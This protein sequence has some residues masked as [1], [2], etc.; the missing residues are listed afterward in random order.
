MHAS[1]ASQHGHQNI[2]IHT[3]D[4]DVVVLAIAMAENMQPECKLWV[5]IG[6]GNNLR[7]ITAQ[8]LAASLGPDRAKSLPVFHAQSGCDTVSSFAGHG[9]KTAW[10]TWNM[11]P[12]LTGALL[13]LSSASR[14]IPEDVMLTIKRFVILMYD[15]TSTCTNI[16]K[17]RKNIFEKKNNV[18]LIQVTKA[19]FDDHVK[20]AAYQGGHI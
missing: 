18:Q 1:H 2:L 17:A 11:L 6:T 20:R 12:E 13:K 7:Y 10:A 15:R 14:D 4:T 3:V 5:A 16:I 19:A 8:E 9:K